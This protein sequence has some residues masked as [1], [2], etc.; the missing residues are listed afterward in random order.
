MSADDAF[1]RDRLDTLVQDTTLLVENPAGEDTVYAFFRHA[2]GAPAGAV[3]AV[4]WSLTR[5][6]IDAFVE[7]DLFRKN[8]E[9]VPVRSSA[10]APEAVA[11][12]TQTVNLGDQVQTLPTVRGRF[13]YEWESGP[14][15]V[16]FVLSEP[17]TVGTF[18]VAVLPEG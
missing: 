4:G 2:A 18:R 8:G 15:L 17:A 16:R 10:I 7:I 3:F 1:I 12:C 9:R 11:A 5:D 6:N 14:L 13:S